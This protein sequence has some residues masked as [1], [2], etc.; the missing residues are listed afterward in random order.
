V[1]RDRRDRSKINRSVAAAADRIRKDFGRL[2]VLIQNAA[3]SNTNKKPGQSVEEYAKTTR[4]SVVSLDEMRTVWDT[5][6]AAWDH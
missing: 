5:N 3:I 1:P 6:R 4:P 2:D